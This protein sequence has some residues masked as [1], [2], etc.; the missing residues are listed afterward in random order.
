MVA[1]KKPAITGL[2]SQGIYDDIRRKTK[3]VGGLVKRGV[4]KNPSNKGGFSNL[5]KLLRR[6]VEERSIMKMPSDIAKGVDFLVRKA[7]PLPDRKKT[8]LKKKK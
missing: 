8:T 5:D 1:K 4:M 6:P 7:T 3:S 2:H